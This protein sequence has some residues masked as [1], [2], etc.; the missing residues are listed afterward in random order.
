MRAAYDALDDATKAEVEDLV[1]E[2]SL[3]YSRGLLGFADFTEEEKAA[4]APVRQRLV[5]T[6][7]V[8]GRKSLYLASHAGTIVGWP[9]PEARAFLRD[10]IE[11]ATQRAVR[12]RP[13]MAPARPG[14]VG[15]PP[16]HAPGAPLPGDRGG[17]RHA[18]HH[19][20]GRRADGGAGRFVAATG[21]RHVIV[22]CGMEAHVCVLQSALGLKV[23]GF[24]PVVV[25]DAV[26]SRRPESR[27]VALQR[28]RAHD[29]EIVTAEMVVFEWLREAGTPAFKAILPL[30]R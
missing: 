11:H 5:R 15:Q 6:H 24:A 17:A 2:H 30:V 29:I 27:E 18:A 3:I 8:T 12:L 16:D 14:D 7:P 21:S 4:F 9:M 26:A 10:L 13:P 1:C 28:M 19:D 23:L 22:I 20:R 25:A